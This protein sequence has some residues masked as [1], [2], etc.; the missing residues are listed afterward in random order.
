MFKNQHTIAAVLGG[1]FLS[2][3]RMLQS[4]DLTKTILLTAV[5][6]A[7]SYGVSYILRRLIERNSK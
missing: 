2:V 1:M 7:V 6:A 4:N 3:Y 5:S